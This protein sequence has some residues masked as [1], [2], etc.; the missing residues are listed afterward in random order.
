[1][2]RA[3]QVRL[4][5]AAALVMSA[6]L[7]ASALAGCSSR[8][9]TLEQVRQQQ[10]D[11]DRLGLVRT[12]IEDGPTPAGE[13]LD[14]GGGAAIVRADQPS[15]EIRLASLRPGRFTVK[16]LCLGHGT[17]QV[18]VAPGMVLGP[19]AGGRANTA[20]VRCGFSETY[21]GSDIATGVLGGSEVTVDMQ[22]IGQ[23][24]GAVAF[25]VREP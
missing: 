1:M 25:R 20:T 6:G 7:T 15:A 17:V 9:P 4:R 22:A 8:P 11:S 13:V 16:A 23:T 2:R 19:T 10:A 12:A 14:E 18:S 24:D 3:S 21:F 5:G